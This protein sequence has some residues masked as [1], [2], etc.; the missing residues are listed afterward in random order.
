MNAQA[1]EALQPQLCPEASINVAGSAD[2]VRN[3]ERWSHFHAPTAGA[4]INVACEADVETT[5]RWATA[6]QIPFVAQSGGHGW[7]AGLKGVRG[8]GVVVNL[9]GLKHI[10]IDAERGQARL[11]GG[12][13][14]GDVLDA[15]YAA[16]VH[17]GL[18]SPFCGVLYILSLHDATTCVAHSI[19]QYT[20][21]DCHGI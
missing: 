21:M 1:L 15:A 20:V 18:S 3:T 8:D 14:T 7:T 9:R 17:I 13:L 11:A 19:C 12:V 10:Q 4:V 16:K 2:Y 6:H 5:V